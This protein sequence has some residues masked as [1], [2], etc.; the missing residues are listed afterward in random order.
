MNCP[1]C[2]NDY[3]C[4]CPTCTKANPDRKPWAFHEDGYTQS[5]SKCGLTK[6]GDAWMDIEWNQMKEKE[7]GKPNAE[8]VNN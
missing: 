4:P 8:P 1:D 5:C 2:R 6:G 7:N 3:Q